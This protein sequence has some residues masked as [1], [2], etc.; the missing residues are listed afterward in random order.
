MPQKQAFLKADKIIKCFNISSKF[1]FLEMF[2][3]ATFFIHILG[4]G[5]KLPPLLG[6][7]V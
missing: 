1:S 2:M 7:T 3:V 5:L 4:A 6:T